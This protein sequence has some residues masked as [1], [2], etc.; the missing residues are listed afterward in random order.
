M[1]QVRALGWRLIP[2]H[3]GRQ[4]PCTTAQN[5]PQWIDPAQ[6]VEQGRQEAAEAVQGAKQ[7][8]IGPGS[9]VYLD[10][11][12]YRP[13]DA[14][15]A[16]AVVDFT[17]GWTQALHSAGYFSGYYSSLNTGVADLAAAARAAPP[18]CPTPSGTPAGTTVR[19]WTAAAS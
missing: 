18:R 6:A 19:A 1:Q 17:L 11:E 15:C 14:G 4:A 3:V 16:K 12:S 9:P 13:G 5:K 2:T 7:V 10:M 8:G